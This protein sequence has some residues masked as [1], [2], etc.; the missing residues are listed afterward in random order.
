MDRFRGSHPSD[1]EDDGQNYQKNDESTE[2]DIH[3]FTSSGLLEYR[4]IAALT[5]RLLP[6]H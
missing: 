6:A 1:E 5:S 2:T 3:R 4:E